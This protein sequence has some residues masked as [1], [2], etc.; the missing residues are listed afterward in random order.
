MS[1]YGLYDE[2]IRLMNDAR[3]RGEDLIT[4]RILLD[5][6]VE[7]GYRGLLYEKETNVKSARFAALK[8]FNHLLRF[9]S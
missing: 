4:G 3:L 8:L 5:D 6:L 2:T 1:G 7:N 9:W